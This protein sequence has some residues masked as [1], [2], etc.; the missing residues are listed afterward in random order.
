MID[1][2][3]K[4]ERNLCAPEEP[5]R[6]TTISTFIASMFSAVSRRLSPLTTEDVAFEK[7]SVSALSLFS[8]SSKLIRVLVLGS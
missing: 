1:A 6:M 8:A 2:S 4:R 5:W 3:R 7:L